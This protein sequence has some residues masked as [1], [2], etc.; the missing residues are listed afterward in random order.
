MSQLTQANLKITFKIG[1]GDF[2]QDESGNDLE[3]TRDV[4]IYAS[5]KRSNSPQFYQMP[6]I[7]ITDLAL[8]GKIVTE[9]SLPGTLPEGITYETTAIATLTEVSKVITG[10][11]RLIPVVQSRLSSIAENFGERIQGILQT[12]AL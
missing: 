4:I 9:D 8:K 2:T 10:N 11:F 6:G 7:R 1:T 12:T 3:V 5:V